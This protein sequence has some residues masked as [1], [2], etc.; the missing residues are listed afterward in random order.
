MYFNLARCRQREPHLLK[1]HQANAHDRSSPDSGRE[2]V[3][4]TADLSLECVGLESGVSKLSSQSRVLHFDCVGE[5]ANVSR[6]GVEAEPTIGSDRDP[7][8]LNSRVGSRELSQLGQTL[9]CLS[10]STL[11]AKPSRREGEDDEQ[12]AKD[13]SGLRKSS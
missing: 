1:K 2:A 6:V 12:E 11:G 3:N 9:E 4:P 5:S 7:L 10:T 8:R 13:D